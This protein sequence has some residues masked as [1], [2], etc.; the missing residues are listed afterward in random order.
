MCVVSCQFNFSKLLF[1][2]NQ[3]FLEMGW[4]NGALLCCHP[5]I[6]LEFLKQHK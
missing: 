3:K 4:C 2:N 1:N 6:P 5:L